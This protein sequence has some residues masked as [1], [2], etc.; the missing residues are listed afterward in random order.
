MD[1]D[2]LV[3]LLREFGYPS[4]GFLAKSQPSTCVSSRATEDDDDDARDFE[5]E[6]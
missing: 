1:R 5:R 6:Y 4:F 2:R 3:L